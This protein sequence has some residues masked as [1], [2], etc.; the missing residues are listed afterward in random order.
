MNFENFRLNIQRGLTVCFLGVLVHGLF[1][2][3]LASL[4]DVALWVDEFQHGIYRDQ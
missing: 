2:L 4:L 3:G 1:G